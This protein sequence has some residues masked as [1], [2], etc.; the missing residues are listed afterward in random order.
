MRRD[1]SEWSRRTMRCDRWPFLSLSLLATLALPPGAGAQERVGIEFQV[2]TYTVGSQGPGTYRERASVSMDSDGD[3]VVVWASSQQD[4]AIYGV[5]AQRFSSTGAV[6]ATE[7]QVNTYTTDT[8]RHPAVAS[9]ADGAFVVVWQSYTQDGGNNYGV[10]GRRFSNT[11]DPLAA[12]FQVTAFTFND[13][14]RPSVSA[15]SDGGFVAV[16]EST[17]QDGDSVGVVAR[18]FSSAGDPL[19][20]ELVVNTYLTGAQYRAQVAAGGDGDFVV[21]WQSL[22]QDGGGIGIFARAFSSTGAPLASEFQVDSFTA[23]SP[24]YL[25]AAAITDGSFVVAWSGGDGDGYGVFARRVSSAGAPLAAEFQVNVVTTSF[26]FLPSVAGESGGTFVT[27][28]SSHAQDYS[29]YGVFGRRFTSAGDPL[30]SEF[31]VNS[32]TGYSQ[33]LSSVA[34]DAASGFV[35]AWTGQNQ[36]GSEHGVFAQRFAVP[37]LFDIDGNGSTDALTDGLLVLRSLFGFTD[38]VLV[39]GAVD[40]AECSRCD[41]DAIEPYLAGLGLALD[42]DDSGSAEALTDGLLLVRSLF[43]FTGNP[44]ISGA[45]DLDACDSRCTAVAI[46]AYL[47]GLT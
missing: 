30:A 36:D 16:W 26:Q 18:R 24:R 42:I 9:G 25:D 46:E 11:G 12:E 1:P 7:F 27:T 17:A 38:A 23:G 2:N 8:Q 5:F 28:W 44:L 34:T 15:A 22:Y 6:L 19:A 35:V 47:A 14:R 4:G 31:Q 39:A 29:G 40:L 43:G 32:F 20:T 33:Y 37:I 13:Q 21:A 3:F 45:V 41:S 10:F